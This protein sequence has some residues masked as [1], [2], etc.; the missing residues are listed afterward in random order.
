MANAIDAAPPAGD[1]DS[2]EST[3]LRLMPQGLRWFIYIRVSTARE[4]MVSPDIQEFACRRLV[5][6]EWGTV[7]QVVTDL[8]LSGAGFAHRKIDWMIDQI[9]QGH[10]DGV[11]LYTWDRFGRDFLESK[12]RLRE[13]EERA[14]G[15]ARAAAEDVDASTDWGDYHRDQ[16]LLMAELRRKQISKS[17]KDAQEQRKRTGLPHTGR[18]I[19][20][21]RTCL[22]CPPRG[23]C[24]P[25]AAKGPGRHCRSCPPQQRC[26]RCADRVLI[27]DPAVAPAYRAM[28]ERAVAGEPLDRLA[29]EMQE[30]GVR[31][32]F[33]R[34]ITGTGWLSIL[35]TG[36]AAGL[37]RYHSDRQRIEARREGRSLSSNS[38]PWAY[39]TW[40]QGSH[41][42]IVTQDFFWNSYVPWRRERHS[43]AKPQS[44]RTYALT[45]LVFC[46]HC[47][48][49]CR[50]GVDRQRGGGTYTH[51]RC[52]SSLRFRGVCP[53][54]SI[55]MHALERTV[56]CWLA[57]QAA[58][59][60][61]AL[62]PDV[63]E[64][65]ER[66]DRMLSR[67]S[68]ELAKE[69]QALA[70]LLDL[71]EDPDGG[72]SKT[73]YLQRK[74]KREARAEVI[75]EGIDHLRRQLSRAAPPSTEIFESLG[76]RWDQTDRPELRPLLVQVIAKVL[77]RQGSRW[78][79]DRVLI[80]P[81]WADE[82]ALTADWH[83]RWPDKA[84]A[85][86][87]RV[88]TSEIYPWR[89]HELS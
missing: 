74:A 9:G 76:K 33:G 25:C 67:L 52:G 71:Y 43:I 61:S 72:L 18:V 2:A 88:D 29:K 46:A 39:D 7:V 58:G 64:Q 75:G 53:G 5:E 31:S 14:G 6:R 17:W 21:Y 12:A 11:V 51:M 86:D 63:P 73:D 78:D 80:V 44:G 32:T 60:A 16:L 3:H 68:T 20:G 47:G 56:C 82:A 87:A 89:R 28:Y 42:P 30:R 62:R 27:A 57:S 69:Q 13:L 84:A 10:A 54:T 77:V 26:G 66:Q 55:A 65:L 41:E 49:R 81:T 24:A 70:R 83:A 79:A 37:C 19:F 59:P 1:D 85:V 35:D 34:K 40:L 50:A 8:D 22:V 45:G 48:Q 15:V 36:F 38:A 23:Q 4:V